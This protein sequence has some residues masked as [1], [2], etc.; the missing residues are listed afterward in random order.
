[1]A[2][3]PRLNYADASNPGLLSAGAQVIP[4]VKDFTNG[5]KLAG[6]SDVLAVYDEGIW[7]PTVNITSNVTITGAV[8]FSGA[9][10]TRVGDTVFARLAVM[11]AATSIKID[12]ANGYTYIRLYTTGLP[13]YGTNESFGGGMITRLGPQYQTLP[14]SINTNGSG[15]ISI[16]ITASSNL[17]V[18]ANDPIGVNGIYFSYK[19]G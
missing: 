2:K 17:G 15:I 14:I 8:A 12:A 18:V 13:A 11:E 1:M 7:T 4:G 19:I 5:L 9:T 16:R 10:Y 3:T 6:N